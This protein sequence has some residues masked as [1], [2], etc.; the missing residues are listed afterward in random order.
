MAIE[1]S[2]CEGC[3]DL[4]QVD[5]IVPDDVWEKIKPEGKPVGD[6]LLCGACIMSHIE[7]TSDYAAWELV[8]I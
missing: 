7:S 5:L 1:G 3:G 8:S 4:Y 2:L 6:G